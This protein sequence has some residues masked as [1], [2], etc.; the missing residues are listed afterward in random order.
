MLFHSEQQRKTPGVPSEGFSIRNFCGDPGNHCFMHSIAIFNTNK[1]IS[2]SHFH[3]PYSSLP[4]STASDN[5][6]SFPSH[7]FPHH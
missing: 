5:P 1:Y 3:K 2:E 7:H 4:E 6:P